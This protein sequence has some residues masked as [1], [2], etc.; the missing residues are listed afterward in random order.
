MPH[1]LRVRNRLRRCCLHKK[2]RKKKQ[3]FRVSAHSPPLLFSRKKT[4]LLPC[5]FRIKALC[6]SFFLEFFFLEKRD[7]LAP[8]SALPFYY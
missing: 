1:L 8:F 6:S 2:K 5:C 3:P 4:C 7:L